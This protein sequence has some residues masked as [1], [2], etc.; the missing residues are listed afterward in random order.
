MSKI[1][2][3][4]NVALL[5]FD[6]NHVYIK[7]AVFCPVTNYAFFLCQ[8]CFM[9]SI[10]QII[11]SN[12]SVCE[13]SALFSCNMLCYLYYHMANKQKKLGESFEVSHLA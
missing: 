8:V 12:I 13:I 3:K 6:R 2:G 4:C 10:N 9:L 7:L 1:I 5:N 11:V